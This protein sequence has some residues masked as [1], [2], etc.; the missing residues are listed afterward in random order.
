VPALESRTASES[1]CGPVNCCLRRHPYAAS[2]CRRSWTAPFAQPARVVANVG[3]DMTFG[4]EAGR[5]ARSRRDGDVHGLPVRG[6]LSRA[7][8]GA[9]A[10]KID[11]V[12][13]EL[14]PKI[15][16]ALGVREY[17]RILYRE[18]LGTDL[19]EPA[20]GPGYAMCRW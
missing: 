4:I 6:R 1:D 18:Y 8:R 11:N 17:I 20:Y 14:V 2:P 12:N 13:R 5:A 19:T 7:A 9:A 16:P 3:E 15:R 10:V